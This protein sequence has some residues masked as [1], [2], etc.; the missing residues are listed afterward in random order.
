MVLKQIIWKLKHISVFRVLKYCVL[1]ILSALVLITTFFYC[2][3]CL[4]PAAKIFLKPFTNSAITETNPQTIF[5]TTLNGANFAIVYISILL[6]LTALIVTFGSFWWGRKLAMLEK[7][8]QDYLLF[9]RN[10]PL[11]AR[12]TTAKIFVIDRRFSEAW[13]EI[14]ELPD[15]F[16]YEVPLFKAKILLGQRHEGS[17]F[18]SIMKLLNKASSFPELSEETK[19]VIDCEISRTYFTEKK[20]YKKALE[21]AERA[22]SE[23]Y[24]Y[25]TAYNAKALSLR[26]LG[27]LDEAITTLEEIIIGDKN[28]DIAYY[29]LACYYAQKFRVEDD[30]EKK[31]IFKNKAITHFKTAIKFRLKSKE[32]AKTD[33]D[34]DPIRS[35][36]NNLT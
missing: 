26:H 11:E 31:E 29:N 10:S 20:D 33:T 22:I 34:L 32:F 14:K 18:S 1:F 25:C 5:E 30:A 23:D 21:Y 6:A 24:T 17:I 2:K 27:N 12:L 4:F 9:K 35:E 16:N 13:E 36:I 8:H 3:H 19:S 28:Y 15:D 7:C